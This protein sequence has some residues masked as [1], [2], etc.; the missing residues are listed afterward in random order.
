M[1]NKALGVLFVMGLLLSGCASQ[2][3]GDQNSLGNPVYYAKAKIY[4]QN[5]GR[6]MGTLK[7]AEAFG[8]LKVTGEINKLQSGREHGISIYEFGDCS[9]LGKRYRGMDSET[10]PAIGRLGNIKANKSGTA[11]VEMLVE[12]L[13][14]NTG[15]YP[16]IGRSIAIHQHKDDM[17]SKGHGGAGNQIACGVIGAS[18]Q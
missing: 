10:I 15:K 1:N 7:F 2:F 9:N 4:G 16:I 17:V 18:S 8:K 6:S 12:S 3:K 11:K 5:S 14:I 13:S